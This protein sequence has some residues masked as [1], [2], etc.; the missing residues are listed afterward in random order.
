VASEHHARTPN[1]ADRVIGFAAQL[2]DSIIMAES[3]LTSFAGN[4]DAKSA[5]K[6]KNQNSQ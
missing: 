6:K 2:E 4:K 1:L 5:R 3:S